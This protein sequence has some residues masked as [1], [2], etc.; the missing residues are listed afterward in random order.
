M[1]TQYGRL[2]ALMLTLMA[3]FGLAAAGWTHLALAADAQAPS[4]GAQ[5]PAVD[6]A[7]ARAPH[8]PPAD[9]SQ[10]PGQ[11]AQLMVSI[12]ELKAEAFKALRGGQFDRT[13]ELLSQAARLVQDPVLRQMAD[14]THEF[15]TQRQGFLAERRQQ[16]EKAVANV[17]TLLEHKKDD[18]AVD[19]AARAYL[20]S[21]NKT[22][23]HQQQWVRELIENASKKAGEYEAQEQWI[24]ALRLYSDLGSVEPANPVW[25]EKLKNATRRLRLLAMYTPDVL[26]EIQQAEARERREVDRLVNPEAA[27]QP[28]ADADADP[29]ENDTFRVHW[30]E[31]LRGIELQ[32]L[33]ESL[34][35]A[36]DHYYRQT[37]YR[38]MLLGGL[39]SLRLLATTTGLEQTFAGLGDA[40]KRDAFVKAVDQMIRQVQNAVY[41]EDATYRLLDS[42]SELNRKTV[43]LPEP[44]WVSEF[45]DG[46][47]A[48]LDPFTSMIWP[49]DLEEFNKTTQGEFSGVGIQIQSDPDGSLRVVSPIE[50]S[51]AYKAGIKAG[52]IITH[53]DGKSAKGI[54]LNQAVKT[55]TGPVNTVVNLTVRSP[56]GTVREYAI[57]RQTIKVA[58][59]KGWRH[60][61]GGGWEYLID[62][63]QKIAYVRITNFTRTTREELDEAVSQMLQQ[64][65]KALILDLRY[66]PGGLLT[67]ATEV[68][69][70]FLTEGLIVTTR[71]DRILRGHTNQE[72]IARKNGDEFGLPMVVL[73]N[74]YSASASEIVSGA[75]QDDQRALI[76]GER[77]FGK[78]SVQMLFPVARRAAYLKLTTSQY[79]LPK[80][81]SIHRQEN[82]LT[83]GVD[84]DVVVEM[85]P[86]QM[87]AAIDARQ[88]LDILRDAEQAAPAEGEQ[89]QLKDRATA[90]E[91]AVKQAQTPKRD[92]L[93]ID[94][95]L[96]A[97]LL[98]LRL[99]LNGAAL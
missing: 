1:K 3:G 55:I 52:D 75:L 73:V 32:M 2:I 35:N 70:K 5:A 77:T 64:G 79:Y 21:D 39:N 48:Q 58:S 65:A 27:T 11:D 40:Q 17:K 98:L 23:F 87:R 9:A 33:K 84:P 60:K 71:P 54:S 82:S 61:P 51:P 59:V 91:D 47:F 72:I 68:C 15:E 31:T 57:T 45:A 80:G 46:A 6:A 30:E 63:E 44:V 69:D 89:E 49:A 85:T 4:A 88:E 56:D 36:N 7:Q 8:D 83:W 92:P 94:P 95:Q 42:F 93:A 38:E 74:Q 37:S 25:K 41:T 12:D 20:L 29:E 28:V 67:A 18:Y 53:I 76:V 90:V 86:E 34:S 24:K 13:N 99:Q 50:D 62:P 96:S 43:A 81:R 26:K 14:W 10:R 78:G 22:L 66:N 97:G 19:Y 16:Y